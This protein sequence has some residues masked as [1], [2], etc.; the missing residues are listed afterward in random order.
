MLSIFCCSSRHAEKHTIY[1]TSCSPGGVPTQW[2]W[3]V[4]KALCKKP[5]N[6]HGGS[7]NLDTNNLRL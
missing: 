6:P 2:E 4:Q 1:N 3:C 5:K 7:L